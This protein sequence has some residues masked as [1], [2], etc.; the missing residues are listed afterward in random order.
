MEL[1]RDLCR[2]LS[3]TLAKRFEFFNQEHIPSYLTV[4]FGLANFVSYVLAR[5]NSDFI[6]DIERTHGEPPD[7]ES[8]N[9]IHT[10][11]LQWL[12]EVLH[13]CYLNSWKKYQEGD[14]FEEWPDI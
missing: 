14:G 5:M 8:M 9:R 4:S 10:V 3:H 12:C 11:S 2:E 6:S 13:I 1:N 7:E